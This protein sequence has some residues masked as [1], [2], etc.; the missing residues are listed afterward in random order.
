MNTLQALLIALVLGVNACGVSYCGVSSC[1]VEEPISIPPQVIDV[2]L[3]GF[4]RDFENDFDIKVNSTVIIEVEQR[5]YL[6][7]CHF[8][9]RRTIKITA[10]VLDLPYYVQK[11]IIYHELG[12][13]DL[14]LPHTT[15]GDWT[16][17]DPYIYVNQSE[18][19]KNNWD[20]LLEDLKTK[21]V[22]G[23]FYPANTR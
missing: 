17:T 11:A 15:S 12:H 21:S 14:M 23:P 22:V 18:Y 6:G 8:T 9:P 10:G 4:I 2:R 19:Y 20:Y 13:C 7:I 1:S 16:L 5:T 3:E